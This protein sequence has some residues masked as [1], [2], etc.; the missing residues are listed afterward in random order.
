MRNT[1]EETV[2][3]GIACP[4]NRKGHDEED[5]EDDKSEDPLQGN[6]LDRE[7]LDSEC[8]SQLATE[9]PNNSLEIGDVHSVSRLRQ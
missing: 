2:A 3:A 7:L 4:R 9:T 8:C 6:N 5:G 1:A